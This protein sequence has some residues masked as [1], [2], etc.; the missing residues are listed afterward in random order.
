[1]EAAMESAVVVEELERTF[2][3][4]GPQRVSV[5][6]LS[7]I[8]F[9]IGRGE[10]FGLLGPNGA[11]KTT[12]VKI[13]CTLLL[14]TGGAARV[15]G[16]DVITDANSI[17]R[18]INVVFGGERG[19][20]WRL[21]GLD[22]LKYFAD[23]YKVPRGRQKALIEGLLDLVG[24]AGAAGRRVETY[25]KGMRQ[26]LSLARAL[27]NDPEVLFLDEPT[28]GLDPVGAQEVR[29]L[30]ASLSQRG[31]SVLLTT[32]YMAEAEVLCDRIAIINKGRIVDTGTPDQLKRLSVGLS[33]VEATV[34]GLSA[35][36][37]ARIR[38][39]PGGRAVYLVSLGSR[40]VV[41][42][43]TEDPEDTMVALS[44]LLADHLISL[45]TRE[46]ALE[47]AYLRLVGGK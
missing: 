42:F 5:K 6:A 18:R 47:D 36:S 29:N 20:Y 32:H 1:M 14:P 38:D 35:D 33:V 44:S 9:E 27:I 26:R 10:V 31:V 21:T 25:S 16:W 30:V 19:L 13:L 23:L 7:G 22:N 43:P 37:L 45:R 39:L 41:Q 12:T 2:K 11:G 46:A 3:P 17:R 28:V 15:L 4:E 8:S 40:T 24:L 34:S